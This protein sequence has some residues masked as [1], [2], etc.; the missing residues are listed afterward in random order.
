MSTM[1]ELPA[2][3]RLQDGR[4]LITG[5]DNFVTTFTSAE[6]YNPTTNTFSPAADMHVPR[7][8][9]GGTLLPNGK[10]LIAGCYGSPGRT[11][12]AQIYGPFPNTRTLTGSID[13]LRNRGRNDTSMDFPPDRHELAEGS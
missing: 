1:R 2:A 4:V 7:I 9:P 11:A 8:I 3:V 6:I 10:V 13:V 12:R 5:G